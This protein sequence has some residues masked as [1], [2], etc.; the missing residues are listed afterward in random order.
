LSDMRITRNSFVCQ[1]VLLKST[2]RQARNVT[3]L[4]TEY[5]PVLSSSFPS[6]ELQDLIIQGRAL[7]LPPD[8]DTVMD[9][10][11]V[12]GHNKHYEWYCDVLEFLAFTITTGVKVSKKQVV[13]D[14]IQYQVDAIIH[15]Y[16]DANSPMATALVHE[17]K[18][19]YEHA[20]SESQD[21][22]ALMVGTQQF[23]LYRTL[24]STNHGH[25]MQVAHY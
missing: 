19:H 2:N 12:W 18:E 15:A 9:T 5:N 25:T 24:Q 22:R 3:L 23:V 8:L 4:R 17:W 11:V 21:M 1:W 6:M 7:P 13:R 20:Y 10:M 14:C 16:I